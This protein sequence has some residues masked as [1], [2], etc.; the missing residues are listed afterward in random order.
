MTAVVS[1]LKAELIQLPVV[2]CNDLKSRVFADGV[3]LGLEEQKS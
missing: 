1:I 3:V 2:K